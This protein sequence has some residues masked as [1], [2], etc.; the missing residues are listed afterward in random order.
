M[1]F[2]RLLS[3]YK[4]LFAYMHIICSISQNYLT[5]SVYFY[6][7]G[8]PGFKGCKILRVS[9]EDFMKLECLKSTSSAVCAA[10]GSTCSKPGMYGQTNEIRSYSFKRF[11]LYFKLNGKRWS[12][13]TIQDYVPEQFKRILEGTRF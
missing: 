7:E 4:T 13:D 3:D 12:L 5:I 6:R 9:K 1:V 2:R 10:R 8:N 11:V